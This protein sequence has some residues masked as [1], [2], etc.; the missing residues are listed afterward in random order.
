M[1]L[2]TEQDNTPVHIDHRCYARA[3]AKLIPMREEAFYGLAGEAV[4][5]GTS[6]GCAS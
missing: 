1:N 3:K 5:V 2:T 4:K 6:N